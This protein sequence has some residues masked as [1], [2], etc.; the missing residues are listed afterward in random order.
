MKQLS[1]LVC[2]LVTPAVGRADTIA[3]WRFGEK[4][5]GQAAEVRG[6]I[7]DVSGFGNHGR[8]LGSAKYVRGMGFDGA[9]IQ[10]NGSGLLE[11]PDAHV[12]DF[13]G[14]FTI[15]AMV[16]TE[17]QGSQYIF[18]RSG[19][20]GEIWIRQHVKGGQSAAVAALVR[21]D[22]G[23]D[24]I[25]SGPRAISDGRFHHVALVR[26]MKGTGGVGELVLYIDGK[27]AAS[28]Q[29]PVNPGPTKISS[30]TSIGGLRKEGTVEAPV[31]TRGWIGEIDYVRVSDVALDARRFLRPAG[32]SAEKILS[33]NRAPA[34]LARIQAVR[35]KTPPRP[36]RPPFNMEPMGDLGRFPRDFEP[37][38]Q[39]FVPDDQLGAI[40]P[41]PYKNFFPRCPD[42]R[43]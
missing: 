5:A 3:F 16:R 29:K 36:V 28:R 11:V 23:T 31:V 24:M 10:W 27:P 4:S 17:Q 38:V 34:V 19:P 13:R 41:S 40:D 42:P 21:S 39:L 6:P 15:E 43:F 37:H 12:F 25:I 8:L 30:L 1:L 26:R 22:Q 32:T 20:G 2:L 35:P 18:I 33:A 14:D 9:A 7:R